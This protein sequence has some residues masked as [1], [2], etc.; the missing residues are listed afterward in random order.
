MSPA[1]RGRAKLAV[2]VAVLVALVVA[3]LGWLLF[4]RKGDPKAVSSAPGAAPT[5]RAPAPP[6]PSALTPA[7]VSG[8][9]RDPGGAPVAGAN[10]CAFVSRDAGLATSK[11]RA[12]TC[13]SS[14]KDGTYEITGLLPVVAWAL[15][16]SSEV[17]P[18]VRWVDA[19]GSEWLRLTTGEA[20]TAVDFVLRTDGVKLRGR[21]HDATGG[22]VRRAFVVTDPLPS[23]GRAT[24]ISDDEG[25]FAMIVEPGRTGLTASASGYADGR[26]D[27]IAPGHFFSI[28]LVAGGTLVGRTVV[29]G[30]DEPVA[31]AKV[32]AIGLEM[33]TS[34]VAAQSDGSG[35]FRIEGLTPGRYRVEATSEG[36]EGYSS[37]STT[38]GLGETSEELTI[39]M[40]PAFVVSGVVVDK[41]TG[42][43][44][45]EGRVVITDHDQDEF[46]QGA[47]QPDGTVRMASVIPGK[48]EVEVDCR[49]A[50]GPKKLPPL[51]I[52]DR[53]PPAQRW[54]VERGEAIRVRVFDPDKKPVTEARVFAHPDD[55]KSDSRE[56]RRAG[57][58]GSF[59]LTGLG[60]GDHRVGASTPTTTAEAKTVAVE[61]GRE[62]TVE[63]VLSRDA[64]LRG[65]VQ[66]GS[67][68]PVPGVQIVAQGPRNVRAR[69][70]E[71]GMFQIGSLVPG[72]YRVRV[73]SQDVR[74]EAEDAGEKVTLR[75]GETAEITLTVPK[76]EG[77]IE[78]K[79]VDAQGEPVT[80]AYIDST[81]GGGRGGFRGLGALR[82][83]PVIT[84]TE[85][86]FRL[87]GLEPGS[88]D[89]RATRRG[90]GQAKAEGVAVGTRDLVLRIAKGASIGGTLTLSDGQ[91]VERFRLDVHEKA[92]FSRRELFF[93]TKE[94][95]LGDLPPGEYEIT[96]ETPLGVASTT[97]TLAEGE[98]KRG[99]ALRL[100]TRGTVR[101]R[102]VSLEG[103]GPVVGWHVEVRGDAA[104]SIMRG[105]AATSGADGAFEITGVLAGS[106]QLFAYP[107][108][109]HGEP[110]GLPITVAENG[111]TDAG[112]VR[113]PASRLGEK[114]R[115]ADLGF[116]V[117]PTADAGGG[118]EVNAVAGPAAEAGLA[119]GDVVVSVDGH[120]VRGANRYLFPALVTV[121]AG[122][123]VELTLSRGAKVSVAATAAAAE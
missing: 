44:C 35:K 11:E 102:L 36:R 37:R 77:V 48:Y 85:G 116:R 24:A 76:R 10:V 71:D 5:R 20:R 94:F 95:V 6:P 56:L 39:Q 59:L 66:D 26:A 31:G 107:L 91:A 83:P 68:Q 50:I 60:T 51:V 117:K 90:A 8:T 103:R 120:D 40:D 89:V 41:A 65:T 112:E 98:T 87:T 64:V 9:V 2:V 52:T 73:L 23:G 57:K 113:V 55:G 1:P 54:E 43:P 19:S 74:R 118:M 14:G 12:P 17:S 119:V 100:T 4:P 46:S 109:G 7:R 21:V 79:V 61:R 106:F 15:S 84:D 78:G 81:R 88:Y 75:A 25:N 114:E 92:G 62:A 53:D 93:H 22:V 101:G 121:P 72:E 123:A 33:G 47:I 45:T 38:L 67:K 16:A 99:I 105:D 34:R 86:R 13:A 82:G 63:L 32:E 69:S 42:A 108:D 27:G 3:G 111:V 30:T 70:G 58:D 115:A 97:A 49:L 80:D 122:R 110:V 18:P 29:A 96:A 28:Y 104:T